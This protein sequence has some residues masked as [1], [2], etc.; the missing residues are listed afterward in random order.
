MYGSKRGGVRVTA[1]TKQQQQLKRQTGLSMAGESYTDGC[2]LGTAA[3][4]E[5]L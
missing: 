1:H 3:E 4:G 2:F 5:Q